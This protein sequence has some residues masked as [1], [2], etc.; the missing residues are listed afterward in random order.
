MEHHHWTDINHTHSITDNGHDHNVWTDVGVASGTSSLQ[1]LPYGYGGTASSIGRSTT[2]IIIN[3]CNERK[4][5]DGSVS[6]TNSTP[7]TSTDSNDLS[8]TETRPTNFTVKIWK[9][10][11]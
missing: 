6:D 3:G 9:R 1:V 8:A 5:S 7:R 11:A 10:T 2:G 4:Y